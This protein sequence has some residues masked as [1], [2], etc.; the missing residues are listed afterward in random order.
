MYYNNRKLILSIFWMILG[1][2]LLGLSIAEVL[3]SS[4]Y[5]G[6][7]G[8]LIAVGALQLARN[9]RYRKDPEYREKIDT[10]ANDERNS[11]LRMKSWSW[12]GYIV[13]LA[14]GFGSVAAMVLGKRELQLT[15][16][17]SVW[18]ILV[19]YWIS[20]FIISKKY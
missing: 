16:A 18:L 17:Y 14:E 9:L 12:T 7:G 15:L 8:G 6:M 5:A 13:V 11:F 20:F 10:E 4:M 19:V 1:A 2:V 3:D